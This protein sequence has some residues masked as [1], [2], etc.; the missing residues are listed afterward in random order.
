LCCSAEC[1]E[2]AAINAHLNAQEANSEAEREVRSSYAN[3]SNEIM[4]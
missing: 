1:Q 3:A 4:S 2:Q